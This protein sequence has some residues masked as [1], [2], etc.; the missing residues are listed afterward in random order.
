MAFPINSF[1]R[2]QW[3]PSPPGVINLSGAGLGQFPLEAQLRDPQ[4]LGVERHQ[5][6]PLGIVA[7]REAIAGLYGLPVEE[8]CITLGATQAN[9][10]ALAALTSPGDKVALETPRFESFERSIQA[11][12]CEA[13]PLDR[14]PGGGWAP[15]LHQ[16][17]AYL[18]EGARVVMVSDPM[19][20]TGV[21]LDDATFGALADLCGEWGATLIVDEI[22]EDFYHPR[23]PRSHRVGRPQVVATSSLS[24]FYGLNH[25]RLGWL[26]GPAAMLDKSRAVQH[27]TTGSVPIATQALG[28]LALERR[29]DIIEWVSGRMG[30]N[31]EALERFKSVVPGLEW[32]E[33][34]RACIAFPRLP[35]GINGDDFTQR[36]L[37]DAQVRVVPGRFFG[38]PQGMRI[39][40]GAPLDDLRRGLNRIKREL[41]PLP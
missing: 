40:L 30:P 27:V 21:R 4:A 32:D 29:E 8:V 41:M 33:D 9:Y 38:M 1:I 18:S 23:A 15:D 14:A 2:H 10:M 3:Q 22:F 24:K 17:R 31:L 36:L 37:K 25:L 13:L 16:L 5:S 20:P 26:L 39:A 28:L 6:S 34:V 7:L 35:E 12:G 19:N 11:L